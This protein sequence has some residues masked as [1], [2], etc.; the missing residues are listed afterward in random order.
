MNCMFWLGLSG[1]GR[2]ISQEMTEE[3]IA[4]DE[5]ALYHKRVVTC[6]GS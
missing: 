1:D 5:R 2:T 4:R 6:G 3:Y